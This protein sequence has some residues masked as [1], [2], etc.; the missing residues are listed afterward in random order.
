MI[1]L[2]TVD[3]GAAVELFAEEDA[4][5]LVGE[6]EF[7]KGQGKVAAAQH[8]VAQAVAAADDE[9]E[10]G[11]T[12]GFPAAQGVGEGKGVE[13]FAENFKGDDKVVVAN[14]LEQPLAFF[15]FEGGDGFVA[16]LG[17]V[18]FVGNGHDL[19]LVILGQP[20][21][22]FVDGALPVFFFDFAN[23]EQGN[24]HQSC[25]ASVWVSMASTAASSGVTKMVCWSV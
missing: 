8:V 6:G 1:F 3:A 15:V 11:V 14:V 9:H 22:V 12:G 4:H 25:G 5:Q 13:F 21:A 16:V 7:G 10:V 2:A 18:F 17:R 19:E 23:A 24:V 20:L